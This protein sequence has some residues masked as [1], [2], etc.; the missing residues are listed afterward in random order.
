MS[1]NTLRISKSRCIL[2]TRGTHGAILRSWKANNN[3]AI[4]LRIRNDY[5]LLIDMYNTNNYLQKIIFGI[6][7][8][9]FLRIDL[10]GLIN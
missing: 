9:Y 2:K 5:I 6:I 8:H 4:R 3:S 7:S 10:S 1:S